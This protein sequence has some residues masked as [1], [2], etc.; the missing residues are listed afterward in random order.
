MITHLSENFDLN[1]FA[2][3]YNVFVAY[4]CRQ[5]LLLFS[6]IYSSCTALF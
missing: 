4:T 5:V 1:I 3:D 2:K 6:G